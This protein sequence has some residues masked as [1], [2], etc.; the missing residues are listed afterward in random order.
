IGK[1]DLNRLRNT[2]SATLTIHFG[3]ALFVL[4]VAE[5]VG[6]W[7]VN[8]KLVFPSDR[9]I[10]VNIVYQFSILTFLLNIIQVPY[11]ALL[12]ARE[13]MDIYAY[14]SLIEVSLKL[15]AVALLT[16]FGSDKLVTFAILTFVMAFVIRM[17]YQIYCHRKFQESKYRFQYD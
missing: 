12:V 5:T 14:V 11:N 6:L 16:Y 1:G 4:I 17:I 9:A 8:Y 13:K 7:Y 10:A 2:F 3:I 15:V